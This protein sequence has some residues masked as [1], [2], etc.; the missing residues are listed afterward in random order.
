MA[1][2]KEIIELY[3]KG[4]SCNNIAEK[5]GISTEGVRDRLKHN[6]IKIRG[7]KLSG[8]SKPTNITLLDSNRENINELK[9]KPGYKGKSMSKIINM[10]V[11]YYC[12]KMNKKE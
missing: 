11:E 6:N 7:N 5:V 4:V 12:N 3:E 1:D 9:E 10:A 2:T 8:K